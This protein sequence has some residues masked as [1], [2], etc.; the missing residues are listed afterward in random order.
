MRNFSKISS[1]NFPLFLLFLK[2][3]SVFFSHNLIQWRSTVDWNSFEEIHD[4]Y[5][6][7]TMRKVL[8]LSE[9]GKALEETRKWGEISRRSM[10]MGSIMKMCFY[11]ISHIYI[12]TLSSFRFSSSC[13]RIRENKI[14]FK[15]LQTNSFNACK[16]NINHKSDRIAIEQTLNRRSKECGWNIFF[17]PPF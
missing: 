10:W 9:S 6:H 2:Y 1:Q 4:S 15:K 13:I 11:F 8:S 5:K 3:R 14:Y 7:F 17:F 12:F 16:K